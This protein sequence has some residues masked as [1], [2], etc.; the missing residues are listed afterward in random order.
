MPHIIVAEWNRS[1]LSQ[2]TTWNRIQAPITANAEMEM[3]KSKGT[4]VEPVDFNK[5]GLLDLL[6]SMVDADC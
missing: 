3:Y 5:S 6:I 2:Q 4:D 1:A